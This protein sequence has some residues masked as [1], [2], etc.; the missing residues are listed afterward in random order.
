MVNAEES[1]YES[2][3]FNEKDTLDAFSLIVVVPEKNQ[4]IHYSPMLPATQSRLHQGL[5]RKMTRPNTTLKI[6]QNSS[7]SKI[8]RMH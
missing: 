3:T 4:S 8:L 6:A 5:Q 1:L 7:R 2:Y